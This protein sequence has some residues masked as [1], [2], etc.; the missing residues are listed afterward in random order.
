MDSTTS[1][2]QL[3]RALLAH[4]SVQTLLLHIVADYYSGIGSREALRK[5]LPATLDSLGEIDPAARAQ[6][7]SLLQAP[8]ARQ[9]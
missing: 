2:G 1:D 4:A 8:V 6:L 7:E 3:L 5:S 9:S